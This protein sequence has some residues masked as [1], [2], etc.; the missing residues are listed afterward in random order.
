MIIHNDSAVHLPVFE[1]RENRKPGRPALCQSEQKGAYTST[2]A[3][4]LP[5]PTAARL[6]RYDNFSYIIH[7]NVP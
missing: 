7:D 1:K 2:L 5:V 6:I 4:H 3:T